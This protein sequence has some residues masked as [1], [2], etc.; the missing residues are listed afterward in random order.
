MEESLIA[1]PGYIKEELDFKYP[2]RSTID[3]R[4]F[5]YVKKEHFESDL[6]QKIVDEQSDILTG[7]LVEKL[8]L[9]KFENAGLYEGAIKW[10][11]EKFNREKYPTLSGLEYCLEIEDRIKKAEYFAVMNDPGVYLEFY[12]REQINLIKSW[13]EYKSPEAYEI[14]ANSYSKPFEVLLNGNKVFDSKWIFYK[15]LKKKIEEF[16]WLIKS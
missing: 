2:D 4:V 12:N 1:F 13:L 11:E 15:D 10:S 5:I 16:G 7:I 3:G 6:H 9:S 8:A 14:W